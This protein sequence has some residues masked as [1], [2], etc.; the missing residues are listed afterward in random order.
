MCVRQIASTSFGGFGTLGLGGSRLGLG[1]VVSCIP[2]VG[3]GLVGGTEVEGRGK[4]DD[5]VLGPAS[6]SL[7]VC[8]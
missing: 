4:V 2:E 7:P 8:T 6:A 1:G 5:G 3:V